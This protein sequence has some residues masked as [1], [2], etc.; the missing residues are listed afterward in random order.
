VNERLLSGPLLALVLSQPLNTG[1]SLSFGFLTITNYSYTV[2]SSTNLAA[3]NWVVCTN[4]IS[5]G[6]PKMFTTPFASHGQG[7]YRLTSP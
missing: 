6:S 3:T 2:W 5:D 1:T 7:F 4:F